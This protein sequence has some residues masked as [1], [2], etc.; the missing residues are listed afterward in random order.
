MSALIELAVN[1][2]STQSSIC[3]YSHGR[4]VGQDAAFVNNLEFEP[5]ISNH[6]AREASPWWE[7]DLEQV[8]VVHAVHI[9][10]R[11]ED[12]HRFCNFTI[13]HSMDRTIWDVAFCKC[14]P[15]HFNDI[16][17]PLLTPVEC[18]FVRVRLDGYESLHLRKVKIFGAQKI[19]SPV[20]GTLTNQA[21]KAGEKITVFSVLFNESNAFLR[22]LIDNFMHF[23]GEKAFFV[24]NLPE[25]FEPKLDHPGA[26]KRVAFTCGQKRAGLGHW[27]L[28]GHLENVAVA[29]QWLGQYDYFVP[30]ASNSLFIRPFAVELAAERLAAQVAPEWYVEPSLIV[31]TEDRLGVERQDWWYPRIDQQ[32]GFLRFVREIVQTDRL[33]P[34]QI[35]GL[36]AP[37]EQWRDL[38]GLAGPIAEMGKGLIPDN[39]FPMEE[40]LTATFFAARHDRNFTSICHVLW[41]PFRTVIRMDQ[42]VQPQW[43]F[44]PHISM[45]KWFER[46]SGAPETVVVATKRGRELIGMI[47]ESVTLDDMGEVSGLRDLLRNLANGLDVLLV[48]RQGY[49]ADLGN[50]AAH[51]G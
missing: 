5:W 15:R 14:D 12:R 43:H 30:I 34:M 41:H 42:V 21:A 26:L 38:A 10:N 32:Q 29:D 2:P 1:R 4:S 48:T 51:G 9:F 47:S 3:E 35:E 45:V 49:M 37:A 13:L 17:I 18:R 22:L 39:L 16:H 7:V 40:V 36:L 6:T 23:A 27:L 33:V 28:A 20:D 25:G 50:G 44:P 8:C 19:D 24:I 31:E 46:D 11:F